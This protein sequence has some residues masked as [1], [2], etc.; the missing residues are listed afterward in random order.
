MLVGVPWSLRE[1]AVG[2][3]LSRAVL[4]LS[5]PV[6]PAFV[7][8]FVESTVFG[9]VPPAFL[10]AMICESLKVPA[11]VWRATLEGLLEAV[12]PAETGT[13]AAPTLIVWGNRDDFVSRA[14][15]ERLVAAI[16]G[17]QLV[18]YEGTGHVV[19]W[20]QPQRVAEDIAAFVERITA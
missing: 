1:K 8:D 4:A 17:S 18:V 12:P 3:E 10:E 16:P 11:H 13:I 2:S 9:P 20:E 15:Q 14:D 7:R 5:D 6:D 19:H